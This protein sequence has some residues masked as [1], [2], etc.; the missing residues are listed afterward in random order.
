[1]KILTSVVLSW[2]SVAVLLVLPDAATAQVGTQ[3]QYCARVGEK[4][5]ACGA[6][7]PFRPQK[8]CGGLVCAQGNVQKHC[9]EPSDLPPPPMCAAENERAIN[10]GGKIC[11]LIDMRTYLW[12]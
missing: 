7:N 12:I 4:A 10:C 6:T 11:L 3:D 1:M 9:V 5:I 2:A 8:C